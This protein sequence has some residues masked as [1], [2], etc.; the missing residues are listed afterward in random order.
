MEPTRNSTQLTP[1]ASLV[2]AVLIALGLLTT[3]MAQP[4]PVAIG[5]PR[6]PLCSV[7]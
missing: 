2:L 4:K 1:R 3:S 6:C 5:N 7:S